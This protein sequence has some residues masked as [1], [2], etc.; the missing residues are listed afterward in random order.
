M[1]QHTRVTPFKLAQENLLVAV[2]SSRLQLK[3]R[4]TLRLP[5]VEPY[6]SSETQGQEGCENCFI[7]ERISGH[8]ESILII[9][10]ESTHK[11]WSTCRC[12]PSW[13]HKACCP[14]CSFRHALLHTC[15]REANCYSCGD[16]RCRSR[17]SIH[18][19]PCRRASSP[20]TATSS[21]RSP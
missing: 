17:T 19:R 15:C 14:R 7:G 11:L 18:P 5:S 9:Q 2:S 3:R 13:C 1:T 12:C 6:A 10:I 8:L 16:H 21:C 4:L 20:T